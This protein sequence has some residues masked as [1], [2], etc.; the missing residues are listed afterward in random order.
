MRVEEV[1][2]VHAANPKAGAL[3]F[4]RLAFVEEDG[5]SDGFKEGHFFDKVVIA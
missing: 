3:T 1:R 4:Q 5:K 2:I